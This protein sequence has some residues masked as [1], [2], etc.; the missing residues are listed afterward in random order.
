MSNTNIGPD[1]VLQIFP[2]VANGSEVYM[3]DNP[4]MDKFNVSYG[5]NSHIPYEKKREGWL[6]Y[7]NSA[8]HEITYKSGVLSGRSLRLDMYPDGGMWKNHTSYSWKNHPNY[9]FTD[10][11]IDNG[12][13][14]IYIRPHIDLRTHHCA[15]WKLGG[16]DQDDIRSLFEICGADQE[17]HNPFSHWNYAHFPYVECLTNVY[18]SHNKLQEDKWYALKAIRIVDSSKEFCDFYLFEDQYPIDTNG[19]P[20]NTWKIIAH[21]HDAG[22]D[23]YRDDDGNKV[24]CIWKSHK[25]TFR[26]DGYANWDFALMSIRNI[27]PTSKPEIPLQLL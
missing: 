2:T 25:D 15:A 26:S 8:G 21:A 23:E 9:L 17:H 1:G 11:G 4:P 16:R 24:P 18:D 5:N 6:T 13:Y 22:T 12:E 14:T 10:K 7:F 27:N 19:K 20:N 3:M